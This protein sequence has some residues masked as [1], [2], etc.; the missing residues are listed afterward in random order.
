MG[1]GTRKRVGLGVNVDSKP[2]R[3]GNNNVDS[4]TCGIGELSTRTRMDSVVPRKVSASMVEPAY[5]CY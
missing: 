4:G 3:L 5:P 2:C 1:C